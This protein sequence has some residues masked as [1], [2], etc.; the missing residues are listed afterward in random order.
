ME[1]ET[2]VFIRS[3]TENVSSLRKLLEFQFRAFLYL[4]SSL[5]TVFFFSPLLFG[6]TSMWSF[7]RVHHRKILNKANNTENFPRNEESNTR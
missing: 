5:D 4:L 2:V 3:R 7:A 1:A 6:D